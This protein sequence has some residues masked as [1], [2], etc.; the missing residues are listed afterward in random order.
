MAETLVHESFRI[1]NIFRE[2]FRITNNFHEN[3]RVWDILQ[4]KTCFWRDESVYKIS[5]C[6][7]FLAAQSAN[8]S[9]YNSLIFLYGRDSS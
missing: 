1:M 8:Q 9:I 4:E 7:E 2:I 5:F 3:F 6:T